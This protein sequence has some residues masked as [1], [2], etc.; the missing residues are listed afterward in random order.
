M[1]VSELVITF[2]DGVEVTYQEGGD[3]EFTDRGFGITKDLHLVFRDGL[4][5][6]NY[7][8]IP[9]GIASDRVGRR[10]NYTY[11]ISTVSAI[12]HS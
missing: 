7:I 12:H 4:C 6:V 2:Q 8:F 10:L 1:K 11:P 3:V 9:H 5:M